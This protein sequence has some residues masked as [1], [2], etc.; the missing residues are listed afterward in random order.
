MVK[1][2]YRW[3]LVLLSCIYVTWREKISYFQIAFFFFIC[4]CC[5]TMQSLIESQRGYLHLK[6]GGHDL[7]VPQELPHESTHIDHNK[8]NEFLPFK[9]L[10]NHYTDLAE[11][12]TITNVMCC[13]RF[14]LSL[15]KRIHTYQILL[16][17]S[18][19]ATLKEFVRV[20]QKNSTNQRTD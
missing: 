3:V 15:L 9:F 14:W 19:L 4:C 11:Y 16:T 2:N 6:V 5:K 12:W 13:C 7:P 8:F 17:V 18:M 20:P 10:Y 1:E